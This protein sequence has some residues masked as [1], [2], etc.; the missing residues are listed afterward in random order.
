MRFAKKSRQGTP[1]CTDEVVEA[2]HCGVGMASSPNALSGGAHGVGVSGSGSE[3]GLNMGEWYNG[4]CISLGPNESS[5]K[6]SIR[7][8]ELSASGVGSFAEDIETVAKELECA[9]VDKESK[10]SRLAR[11]GQSYASPS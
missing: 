1:E 3:S 5:W 10:S 4:L 7:A 9:E 11:S 8:G 6:A 2:I